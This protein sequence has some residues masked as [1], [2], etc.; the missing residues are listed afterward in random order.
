MIDRLFGRHAARLRITLGLVGM[1]VS[2]FLVAALLGLFPDML[3]AQSRHR[4]ALA[5]ALAVNGSAFITL[6]DLNR[7]ESDLRLVVERNDDLRSAAIRR[8]S[9]ELVVEVGAH[10]RDWIEGALSSATNGQ[11][12]VPIHEGGRSWGAL[13]LRF[14]PLRSPGLAGYLEDPVVRM[15][16]ALAVGCLLM[17]FVFLGQMLRQ[18]DPSQAIPGRVRSALDT[19]AEGLLVIDARRNVVLAN[20]AFADLVGETPAALLGRP[21]AD[22][23]WSGAGEDLFAADAAPWSLALRDAEP[24][25]SRR[26]RLELDGGQRS[27]TFMTNCSPVLAAEGKPQGVLISFD[28][29]TELEQKEVELQLSKEEAEYANRSKSEFLANMSHEIRTPMNA[30]LGFTEVLKRGYGRSDADSARYLDTIASSGTHLL[31]LINDIL[32]LSK[33]EAGRIELEITEAEPRRVFHE[34]VEVLRIRAEEKGIL[35]RYRP[36][37]PLPAVIRS[38]HP[39]IRQILINLVG[40]ALKFTESGTVTLVSR[41]EAGRLRIDVIDTGIGMTEE[42]AGRI[43]ESFGQADSSITRRFGGTGLGLSISKK[44]AEALG[45]DI[46]VT[47]APGAGSTFSVSFDVEVP[48]GTPMQTPE[49]LLESSWRIEE[50]PADGWVFAPQRVLVVDDGEENRSLLELVLG[51]AGLVVECATNGREALER[52]AGSA[53]AAILMDVQMPVMDGYAAVAAMRE[54]GL[55]MPIVALTAHAMKGT[56]ERCRAAGY[57]DYL[58]KPIDLDALLGLLGRLLGAERVAPA[59]AAPPLVSRLNLDSAR[60]AVIVD[61]FAV[62]LGEQLA[63]MRAAL[64]DD[65]RAALADLAHWLKGSA[66]SVGLHEFTVPARALEALVEHGEPAALAERIDAIEAL[67]RRVGATAGSRPR[68]AAGSPDASSRVRAEL[69]IR[70]RLAMDSPRIRGLVARFI[71]RLDTQFAAMRAAQ[72][73]EDLATLADLAHWLKGSGG[74][75]GY[76][77]FTEP[78]AELEAAARRADMRA[79]DACMDRIERLIGRVEPVGEAQAVAALDEDEGSPVS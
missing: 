10:A 70:S 38:D 72:G 31:N 46:V 2:L 50:G 75:V 67:H 66:G 15:G 8:A 62:R 29:I 17:F 71:E 18:L 19:M 79:V 12:S 51:E 9:G 58:P 14:D 21:I 27:A 41:Y 73:G 77:V 45:G 52:T 1:V 60:L 5:E 55:E 44:F 54:R 74:T 28:D 53:Y 3:E 33:V 13:Q 22:F 48:P 23:H 16:A 4:A 69:P 78:A 68:A 47:S 35:L 59:P 37:G 36:D 61:R 39:K 7:L 65:D 40:N 25:M 63:A 6:S 57:S 32:D 56:E 34:I 26:I 76:P 11:I 24:Q 20:Q 42:Q 49:E 64:R 43:F 30:I